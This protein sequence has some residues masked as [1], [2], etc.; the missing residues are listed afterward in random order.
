MSVEFERQAV[1]K[2]GLALDDARLPFW[3]AQPEKRSAAG[4]L[5]HHQIV[6]PVAIDVGGASARTEVRARLQNSG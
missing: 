5:L 6:P 1:A 2:L 4:A 3:R